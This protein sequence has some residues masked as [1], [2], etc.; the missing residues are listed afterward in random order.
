MRITLSIVFICLYT[1]VKC[2]LVPPGRLRGTWIAPSIV[3]FIAR[4]GKYSIFNRVVSSGVKGEEF[5][6]LYI[7]S[8]RTRWY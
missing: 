5:D 1:N 4:G 2:H 7:F 6:P 8:R 3:K